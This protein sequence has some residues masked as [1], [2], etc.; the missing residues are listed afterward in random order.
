MNELRKPDSVFRLVL[1][2]AKRAEQLMEGAKPRIADHGLAKYTSLA[3]AEVEQGLVPWQ[4]LEP[5]EYERLREEE[6]ARK[7]Q[8][9]ERELVLVPPPPRETAVLAS[10]EEEEEE[11]E[12][13]LEEPDELPYEED[14]AELEED[15]EKDPFPEEE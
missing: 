2:A 9:K 11:E 14:L 5:E 1:L 7:E 10:V 13:E 8:E 3:L 12:E 15:S 6:L 4:I